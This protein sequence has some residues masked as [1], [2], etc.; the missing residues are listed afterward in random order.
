MKHN[1][2]I[3]K[4]PALAQADD[5]LDKANQTAFIELFIPLW[6]QIKRIYL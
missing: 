2:S 1:R 3:T 6:Y 5:V 4:L